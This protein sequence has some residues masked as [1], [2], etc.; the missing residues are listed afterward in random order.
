[1]TDERANFQL[2]LRYRSDTTFGITPAVKKKQSPKQSRFTCNR[3][4]AIAMKK[5]P[6]HWFI[7]LLTGLTIPTSVKAAGIVDSMSDGAVTNSNNTSTL[8]VALAVGAVLVIILFGLY[9]IGK[10]NEEMRKMRK[11]RQSGV[12]FLNGLDVSSY[13]Q[14]IDWKKVASTGVSF[15][16]IKATEGTTIQDS[17]F[18]SNRANAKAAGIIVGAYHLFR[19][20]T[21]GQGQID[22]F[23]STVGQIESGELP[24]VLD[25][26]V[27]S[28]WQSF[29]IATRIGFVKDWLTAVETALGVRPIIYIN[30]SDAQT[31]LDNDQSFATDS[32]FVAFPTNASIPVLPRPWSDWTFWQH[33]WQG[34]V[35][36]ISGN[37]DLDY[38]HGT[39]EDLRKLLKA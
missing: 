14:T 36:G 13:Q 22:N 34:T 25:L 20:K 16:Y 19:P 15:A 37:C 30:N 27:P 38:F 12:S 7:L 17:F 32:L 18:A 28:D 33:N 5:F 26:E 31:L 1:L 35:S 2:S 10:S 21:A 29:S 4:G 6:I 23:V 39:L 9:K 11:M 8:S 3:L 24:P